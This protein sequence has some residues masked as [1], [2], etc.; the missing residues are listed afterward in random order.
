MPIPL[1]FSRLVRGAEMRVAETRAVNCALRQA[2]GMGIRSI[3][4]IGSSVEPAD[5]FASPRS[6]LHSLLSA[7]VDELA[8]KAPPMLPK[9]NRWRATLVN[10]CER[11]GG[12]SGHGS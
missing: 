4:E 3:G 11:V 9:L 2:C 12:S 7:M 5:L 10:L 6:S 8:S 1:V